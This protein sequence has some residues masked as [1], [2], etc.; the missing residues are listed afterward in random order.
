MSNPLEVD[1]DTDCLKRKLSV[2]DN[3]HGS[4]SE[5][6]QDEMKT[7]PNEDS[8]E[9]NDSVETSDHLRQFDVLDEVQGDDSGSENGDND[10]RGNKY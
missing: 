4:H 2:E 1:T 9:N 10:Q 7:L 6:N 8:G 3:T 5:D